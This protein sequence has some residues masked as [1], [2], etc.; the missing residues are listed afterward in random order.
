MVV[1][2]N[3]RCCKKIYTLYGLLLWPNVIKML[4]V[5]YTLHVVTF[6]LGT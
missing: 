3:N 5:S 6:R 4:S 2:F 1:K